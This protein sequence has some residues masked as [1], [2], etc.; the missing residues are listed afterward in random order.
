[1]VDDRLAEIERV[2]LLAQIMQIESFD[3][4]I[5]PVDLGNGPLKFGDQL[6]GVLDLDCR[7][8]FFVDCIESSDEVALQEIVGYHQCFAL[9]DQV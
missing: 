1:M 8:L 7:A 4:R 9:R 3:D 2:K 5:V 6:V